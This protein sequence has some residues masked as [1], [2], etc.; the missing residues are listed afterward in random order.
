M[1]PYLTYKRLLSWVAF[2]AVGVS[3]IL[4]ADCGIGIAATTKPLSSDALPIVGCREDGEDLPEGPGVKEKAQGGAV[5]GKDK[6]L[7]IQFV[8]KVEAPDIDTIITVAGVF[9][10]AGPFD[11]TYRLL[12][13]ADANENTG[14]VVAGFSGIDREV[15]IHV[16]ATIPKVPR[17][18]SVVVIDDDA[19]DKQ[20]PIPQSPRLEQSV[21][22]M[23]SVGPG[24]SVLLNQANINFD[25]PKA[26][27]NLS[28]AEVPVGIV[29]QD[30]SG[31]I[32]DSLKLVFDQE[33]YLEQP[34]V[35]LAP[36]KASVGEK[37]R[38]SV[39]GFQPGATFTL[40][41]DDTPMLTGTVNDAGKCNGSFTVPNVPPRRNDYTVTANQEPK[42]GEKFR[43]GF[44]V[45]TIEPSDEIAK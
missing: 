34:T 24:S 35:A 31:K 27:L 36:G 25:I 2:G 9:P 32:L 44:N 22:F 4:C 42:A 41:F 33:E 5:A 8:S 13:N 37:V 16:T 18:I 7:R 3:M 43:Y 45:I 15:V 10:E 11:E 38:F 6:L 17:T 14:R 39:R 20:T 28:A 12:F 30:A 1:A 29:A 19:N 26:L 23:Y 40:L 21:L